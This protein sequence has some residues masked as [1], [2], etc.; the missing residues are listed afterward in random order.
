MLIGE[1]Q[2]TYLQ[3]RKIYLEFLA[4]IKA[5]SLTEHDCWVRKLSVPDA[6]TSIRI[7]DVSD[8]EEDEVGWVSEDDDDLLYEVETGVFGGGEGGIEDGLE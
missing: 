7:H 6:E 2:E 5:K 4:S 3:C 1:D 8:S